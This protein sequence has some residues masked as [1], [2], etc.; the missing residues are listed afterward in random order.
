MTS[1]W[2]TPWNII[3]AFGIVLITVIVS[4]LNK[5]VYTQEAKVSYSTDVISQANNLIGESSRWHTTA[6]QDTNP[7][8]ALMHATYAV[9]YLNAAR[10]LVDDGQMMQTSGVHMPEMALVTS[11]AQQNA[12][13]ALTQMCPNITPMDSDGYS[14][15]T[16]Y[17]A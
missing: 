6:M 10:T 17:I 13:K 7:A 2:T 8:L 14:I 15:Y 5:Q 1:T 12:F 11:T 3:Y 16:G 4:V 9:A